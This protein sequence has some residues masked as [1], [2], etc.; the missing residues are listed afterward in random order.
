MAAD[1]EPL[2]TRLRKEGPK[3][4]VLE[5]FRLAWAALFAP[6]LAP[7][8]LAAVAIV[9]ASWVWV[10]RLD[11]L[12]I[13]VCVLLSLGAGMWLLNQFRAAMTP[14]TAETA[15]APSQDEP[16]LKKTILTPD[17]P[18]GAALQY[19]N[20]ESSWGHGK[21][22]DIAIGALEAA[23]QRG[24]LVAWGRQCVNWKSDGLGNT[25]ADD[26]PLD[27]DPNEVRIDAHDWACIHFW[28]PSVLQP[29]PQPNRPHMA[30][31]NP[32][33]IAQSYGYIR[34]NKEQLRKLYPSMFS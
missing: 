1:K 27:F 32:H 23:A 12:V 3:E 24:S 6:W 9:T 2:L 29:N 26:F 21:G 28:Q 33:Y 19:L 15:S 8:W 20:E 11:P 34:V 17:M 10:S 5:S 30:I 14:A 7:F 18:I 16:A 31:P 4:L 13:W 25:P 22:Y